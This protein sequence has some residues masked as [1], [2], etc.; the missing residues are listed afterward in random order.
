MVASGRGGSN[1]EEE[2][3]IE[4]AHPEFFSELHYISLIRKMY[5]G[6]TY[7]PR[8]LLAHSGA[9]TA[10]IPI[11]RYPSQKYGDT[12]LR[13]WGRWGQDFYKAPKDIF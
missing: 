8:I 6:V 5:L 12:M 7:P 11:C 4:G 3:L 13:V 10:G 1:L 2:A 9:I